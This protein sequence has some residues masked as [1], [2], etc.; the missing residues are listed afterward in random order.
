MRV[1][2]QAPQ[3][4]QR[5]IWH[6]TVKR[7]LMEEFKVSESRHSPA[8]EK[9]EDMDLK[10]AYTYLERYEWWYSTHYLYE[11]GAY[12]KGTAEEINAYLMKMENKPFSFL[13]FQENLLILLVYLWDFCDNHAVSF[14][15]CKIQEGTLMSYFHTKPITAGEYVVGKVSAG[16]G[17]CLI[18]LA[19]LNLLF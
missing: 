6:E 13:F 7:T 19:I 16:F 15:F 2:F 18:V 12:H 8:I 4:M 5:E 10:E 11:N 14:I 1:I 3:K 9:M 17:V